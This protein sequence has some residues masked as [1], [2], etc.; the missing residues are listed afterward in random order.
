MSEPMIA[1]IGAG[2][3]GEALVSGL[4]KAGASPDDLLITER[5][6]ERAHELSQRY[7]VKS[8]SNAEAANQADDH[9]AR[10]QAAGH[11]SA[12]G[13]AAARGHP[14]PPDRDDCGRHHDGR[15]RT[16]ARRRRPGG[17][18]HA[19]HSGAGWRSDERGSPW[20]ACVGRTPRPGRGTLSAGR[21]GWCDFPNRS[22][23]L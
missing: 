18:G 15:D 5:Y 20:R 8:V 4:L 6:E 11:G 19:E 10:G 7:G 9:R 1:V 16:A 3:M 21:A 2:K 12:A 13:R 14:R 17:A 22:S 23:T